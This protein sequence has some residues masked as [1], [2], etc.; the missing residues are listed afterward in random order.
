[1]LRSLFFALVMITGINLVGQNKST[2]INF[3][4]EGYVKA[5]VIKYEVENCG[6]LLELA[7]KDKTK[8]AP[9]KLDE[10]FKKHGMKVWVKYTLSKKQNMSTCMVGKQAEIADVRK[11]K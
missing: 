2:K 8:I 10:A 3:A 1:M 7:N 4:K 11:R 9:D 5:K 6:Y